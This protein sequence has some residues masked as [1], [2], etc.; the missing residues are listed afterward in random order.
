[1]HHPGDE[2]SSHRR[3]DAEVDRVRS[4]HDPAAREAIG[5]DS[6][7]EQGRDLRQRPGGE[8]EANPG[9]RARQAEDRERDRDGREVRAEERGRACREELAEARLTKRLRHGYG[10]LPSLASSGHDV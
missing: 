2:Q 4:G 1:M 8:G 7:D 5:D 3:P 6:A 10:H 9:R